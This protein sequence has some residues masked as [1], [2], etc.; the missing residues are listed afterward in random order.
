MQLD[1]KHLG[2]ALA[3]GGV[4]A[5]GVAFLGGC[6]YPFLVEL[7]SP[8]T[9][10]G[11]HSSYSGISPMILVQF[12]LITALIA[13]P[14]ALALT[15][16]IAWPVF[17]LWVRRGYSNVGEYIGGGVIVSIAGAA[18]ITAAHV[19]GA[20]FLIDSDFRFA[21]LIIGICGPVSG[22]TVW[23]VLQRSSQ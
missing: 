16:G 17:R 6:F 10:S 1:Q 18:V 15:F 3:A 7:M 11:V 23:Y 19:F 14:V 8:H 20:D 2:G 9:A 12:G 21:I 5:I 13:L 4:A 22:L